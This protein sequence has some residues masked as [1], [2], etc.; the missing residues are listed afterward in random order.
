MHVKIQRTWIPAVS[1]E[2]QS[3][4]YLEIQ[5][6]EN[7]SSN[8]PP[9]PWLPS[10]QGN[11]PTYVYVSTHLSFMGM[12]YHLMKLVFSIRLANE[13]YQHTP[14]ACHSMQLQVYCVYKSSA[15][16]LPL[17]AKKQGEG[18]EVSSV[19]TTEGIFFSYAK[20]LRERPT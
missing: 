6:R 11:I 1:T 9:L 14:A 17:S 4:L 10:P 20:E 19:W 15:A 18:P 12:C 16:S 7:T 5:S 2:P 13:L 8:D 3:R